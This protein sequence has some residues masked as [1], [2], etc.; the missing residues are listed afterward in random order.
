MSRSHS[1][2]LRV[3]FVIVDCCRAAQPTRSAR[4]VRYERLQGERDFHA[5]QPTE[6]TDRRK[7]MMI[8][9]NNCLVI[10]PPSC[11]FAVHV[12]PERHRRMVRLLAVC[13]P[14]PRRRNG[15]CGAH[16]HNI[17]PGS[18]A[19]RTLSRVMTMAKSTRGKLVCF[20]PPHTHPPSRIRLLPLYAFENP[21]L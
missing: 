18:S 13:P 11:I 12:L 3:P 19:T 10:T 21:A 4:P 16:S 2:N 6:C 15:I 9:I 1:R 5:D 14:L 8:Q 17:I 20:H 7:L